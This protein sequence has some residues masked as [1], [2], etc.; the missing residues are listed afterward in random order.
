MRHRSPQQQFDIDCRDVYYEVIGEAGQEGIHQI[1]AEALAVDAVLQA[2]ADQKIRTPSDPLKD[3][4]L[5]A[6]KRGDNRAPS[7][8]RTYLSKPSLGYPDDPVWLTPVRMGQGERKSLAW[9]SVMDLEA[10]FRLI[11]ENAKK[12]AAR[13]DAEERLTMQRT[14]E[15]VRGGHETV[16]SALLGGA[17]RDLD[18]FD[19]DDDNDET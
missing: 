13:R 6:V 3:A 8:V 4:I 19:T 16:R 9:C 12:V 18:W 2:I 15:M 11:D 5:S 14:G 10:R 1:E 7:I 17:F